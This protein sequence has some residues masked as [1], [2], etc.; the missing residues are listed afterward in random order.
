MD[1]DFVEEIVSFNSDGQTLDF[2]RTNNILCVDDVGDPNVH[3]IKPEFFSIEDIDNDMSTDNCLMQTIESSYFANSGTRKNELNHMTKAVME[4][5]PYGDGLQYL[6]A[7]SS[8]SD[9]FKV[10]KILTIFFHLWSNIYT[11][12]PTF[13]NF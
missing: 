13:F 6:A 4:S 9:N 5:V 12:L 10:I 2:D 3:N 11:L 7:I 8:F 1:T